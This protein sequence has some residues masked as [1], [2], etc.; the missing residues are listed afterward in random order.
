MMTSR[1][2]REAFHF[3]FLERLLRI[4][5]ARL[6]VLKGG[7]NLRFF[8]H[9]PRYSEDMDL[10][11]L[12]GA[13]PTLRKNG[14]KILDDAAFRRTLRT[15]GITDLEI[16]DPV[17]A[18]HTQTTQRFRVRLVTTAGERLPSKVEFSRRAAGREQIS[19]H[20]QSTAVDRIDTEIARRYN[21][22]SFRCQHYTAEA[23]IVQKV[24]ALAGRPATQAR[25]VFDLDVLQRGGYAQAR[26]LQ[27]SIGQHELALAS[28]NLE[29]LSFDDFSG[30]V[31]EFLDED[32]RQEYASAEAWRSMKEQVENLLRAP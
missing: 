27:R 11:V 19:D 18:K 26:Q 24:L 22:L 8:F 28:Q 9:S 6:F 14:Y 32:D 2:L 4:A 20:M 23:A 10:D 21:R 15:F 3:C 16:N 7:V 13:V 31:L 12:A 30:Q 17:R 25:D 5:D 29:S 1:Q